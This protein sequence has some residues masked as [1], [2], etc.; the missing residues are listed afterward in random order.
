MNRIVPF[1]G[2]TAVAQLRPTHLKRAD[3]GLELPL[4]GVPVAHQAPATLLVSE[5]GMGGEERLHFG[6]DSLHQHPLGALAQHGQQRIVRDA[7][8]WPGQDDNAI[9][10]HGV[11]FLVT[12][13]ITEDTP[14]P[15]QPPNSVIA[16]C[17][18]MSAG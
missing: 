4:G 16:P 14:P 6:L 3:A 2:D 9:L 15:P 7:R 12:S 10:L 5:P 1:T 13:N 8:S 18:E 17:A 11:S